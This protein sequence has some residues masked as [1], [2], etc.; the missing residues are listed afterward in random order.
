MQSFAEFVAEAL[1]SEVELNWRLRSESFVLATFE[2][3]SLAVEVTFEQREFAGPWHVAFDVRKGDASE[4]VHLAFH[5]FNGVFQAVKEF[6]EVR[7]PEVI[8][9]VTKR[10]DLASVYE[11]YLRRERGTLE[12]LGYDLAPPHDVPPYRE[13]MLKRVRPSGWTR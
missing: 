13:F 5:V 3:S 9:F 12:T 8:L 2:I 11:T 6:I 7:E 4:S 10:E 1:Q